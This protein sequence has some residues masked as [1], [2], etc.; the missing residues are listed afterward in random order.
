MLAMGTVS[1]TI[2]DDGISRRAYTSLDDSCTLPCSV[3]CPISNMPLSD[4]VVAPDGYSYERE[5]IV[6]WLR[7]KRTSPVTGDAMPF[8]LLVPNHTLRETIRELVA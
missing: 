6:E 3:I 8:P 2:F 5:C 1:A 4:P 7:R